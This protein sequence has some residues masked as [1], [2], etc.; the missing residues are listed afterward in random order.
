MSKQHSATCKF[1]QSENRHA[2]VWRQPI[3]AAKQIPP[4][5]KTNFGNLPQRIPRKLFNS[6]ATAEFIFGVSVRTCGRFGP[7]Q[8]WGNFFGKRNFWRGAYNQKIQEHQFQILF[9]IHAMILHSSSPWYPTSFAFRAKESCGGLNLKRH[10]WTA[11][12]YCSLAVWKNSFRNKVPSC[13]TSSR[14]FATWPF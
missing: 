9:S 3:T 7:N 12:S 6:W 14:R 1:A 13:R 8:I 2:E 5:Q 11:R 10:Y 4:R